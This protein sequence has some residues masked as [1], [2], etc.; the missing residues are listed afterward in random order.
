MMAGDTPLRIALV[1]GTSGGGVGQHVRS[2]AAGLVDAGHRVVVFGPA[3]T[4][5]LFAF[6]QAGAAF[7]AAEIS[8]RPDPRDAAVA[9]RLRR[10]LAGAD[11]VHAHGFRAGLV[12]RLALLAHPVGWARPPL[13]VTWHN[14][15]L[16]KGLAGRLLAVAERAVAR[17][18]DVTL[19]CSP[20]LVARARQL[21]ARYARKTAVPAPPLPPAG[22]GRDAVRAELGVDSQPLLLAVGRL[23]PQKDYPTL[24]SAAALWAERDPQPQVVVAGD[25]PLE[26]ELADRVAREHLMVR[27]LGRRNDVA[28]LLTAADLFVLPSLW[29]G[30][31]LVAQEAL[32]AG[33]PLVAT[34]VGG[35]PD[36]VGDAAVLV[37]PGDPEALAA[38]VC[39]LLED[40]ARR[41]RLAAAGRQQAAQWPDEAA[42]VAELATLYRTLVGSR[43]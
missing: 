15:V 17:G 19:G 38:A 12:T 13:V 35:I 23:H 26:G 21:G 28:D 37:R 2:V 27:F 3:A 43:G 22:R 29:E 34:A 1:L 32:R 5:R 25:G 10:H 39:G 42:V 18:A 36:L 14:Q 6:T 7:H 20:D 30:Y 16:A 41:A 8:S 24:L 11:V 4:E 33:V 31:P 9:A 40:P